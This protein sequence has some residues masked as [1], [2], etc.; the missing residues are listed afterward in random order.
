MQNTS[1]YLIA[2]DAP[3]QQTDIRTYLQAKKPA[4]QTALAMATPPIPAERFITV[5]EEASEGNFKYL[6]YVI[7]D[8][9]SREPGSVP[10]NLDTLPR[11]LK[12]YYGQFWSY[13]APASKEDRREVWEEWEQIYQPVIAFLGAAREPVT[14][15]WLT[16]LVG[17]SAKKIRGA[18]SSRFALLKGGD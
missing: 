10:L 12:C 7:T 18:L 8:I 15:E 2:W 14:A 13:I 16:T 11:G 6:D 1:E 17:C 5:L 9:A 4:I 3:A